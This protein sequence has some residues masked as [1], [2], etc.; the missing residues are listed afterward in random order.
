MS[1]NN[2]THNVT[3]WPEPMSGRS[4]TGKVEKVLHIEV[5]RG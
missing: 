4:T 2:T 1:G 3:Y 5:L